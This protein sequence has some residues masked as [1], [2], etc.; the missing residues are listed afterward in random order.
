[1]IVALIMLR[2]PDAKLAPLAIASIPGQA[3][4]ARGGIKTLRPTGIG[5]VRV[6]HTQK[7]VF[8]KLKAHLPNGICKS[9]FSG[10][11]TESHLS[12]AQGDAEEGT[13]RLEE[14]AQRRR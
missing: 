1:M 11:N 4:L 2:V 12:D 9:A 5:P 13:L 7:V 14:L 8:L 10:I 3:C 6:V